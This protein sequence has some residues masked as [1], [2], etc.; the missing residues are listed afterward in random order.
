MTFWE[1]FQNKGGIQSLILDQL[2]FSNLR[3]N[4]QGKKTHQIFV[5]TSSS[6]GTF[7]LKT[8]GLL[9]VQKTCYSHYF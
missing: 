2:N 4:F 8:G 7:H 6:K 9:Q 3:E 1:H 5:M